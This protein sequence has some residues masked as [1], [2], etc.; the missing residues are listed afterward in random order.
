MTATPGSS[1]PRVPAELPLLPLVGTVVFPLTLNPLAADRPQAIDAVNRALGANRMV[2]LVL[3][4]LVI[5]L[6]QIHV[7]GR[8]RGRVV[9]LYSQL[10]AGS[11][12]AGAMLI[13]AVAVPRV[14]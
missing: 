3:Q 7:P 9:S 10:H 1:S 6:V 8:V 12:T 11:E 13:G 14:E 5:T 2:L 4:S